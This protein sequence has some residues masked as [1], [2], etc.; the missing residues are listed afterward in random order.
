[1]LSARTGEKK[2]PFSNLSYLSENLFSLQIDLSQLVPDS[3]G[4]ILQDGRGRKSYITQA[5][6]IK[7]SGNSLPIA[8]IQPE[9][10]EIELGEEV[11]LDGSGSYDPE[12]SPLNFNWLV[13]DSDHPLEIPDS[14][15][16]KI[17]L[18]PPEEGDYLLGLMV[19]DGVN[20]SV[21]TQAL[22]SVSSGDSEGCGC[23]LA[24]SSEWKG[25][26]FLPGFF[27]LLF[28]FALK[29]WGSGVNKNTG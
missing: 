8:T 1:L 6:I 23:Q 11:E 24:S 9:K 17:S 16:A 13:I 20:F 22:V 4:L 26:F 12:G 19:D 25:T 21:I 18:Q 10:I 14:S 29:L 2:N 15:Q 5:L 28:L 27:I 7:Q 3:Y